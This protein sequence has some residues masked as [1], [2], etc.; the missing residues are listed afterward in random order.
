MNLDA[1]EVP[2]RLGDLL[3]LVLDGQ[4]PMPVEA[5]PSWLRASDV[6]IG[7]QKLALL[8]QPDAANPDE[9][10]P[11]WIPALTNV[12][13]ADPNPTLDEAAAEFNRLAA[14]AEA[15]RWT[16]V[17]PV[18]AGE[19]S[20]MPSFFH[21]LFNEYIA[22][23]FVAVQRYGVPAPEAEEVTRD[24]F[25]AVGEGLHPWV[26]T[27]AYRTA[28]AHLERTRATQPRAPAPDPNKLKN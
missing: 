27:I 11:L 6:P 16:P 19:D 15:E 3:D 8:L 9:F 7:I 13:S 20:P 2:M 22:E 21:A 24:A 4:I 23:V 10:D 26:R 28:R 17:P 12:F 25:L 1:G 14:L 18:G 5:M